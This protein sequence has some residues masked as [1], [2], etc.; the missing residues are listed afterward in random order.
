MANRKND[1]FCADNQYEEAYARGW[2]TMEDPDRELNAYIT[3]PGEM[4]Q[5]LRELK[6]LKKDL[7]S[8]NCG[9]SGK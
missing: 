3:Y 8:G 1:V 6:E 5:M 2:K 7:H 4:D 9:R